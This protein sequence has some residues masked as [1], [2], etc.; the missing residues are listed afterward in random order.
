[1]TETEKSTAQPA[2]VRVSRANIL[3]RIG[4]LCFADGELAA[5]PA[6]ERVNFFETLHLTFETADQAEAWGV[7][8]QLD[9]RGRVYKPTWQEAEIRSVDAH[10]NVY[11]LGGRVNVSGWTTVDNSQPEDTDPDNLEAVQS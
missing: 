10:G 1:M 8:F 3:R 7:R 11:E 2:A 4:R 9:V 6:P 5:L